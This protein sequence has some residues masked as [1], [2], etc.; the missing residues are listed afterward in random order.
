MTP[1]ITGS[2]GVIPMHYKTGQGRGP[3]RFS[4]SAAGEA[5]S[6]S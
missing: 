5:L 4:L 3:A 1:I 2:A 6:P